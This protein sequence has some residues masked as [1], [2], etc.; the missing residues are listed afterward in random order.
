MAE[1]I[2]DLSEFLL[3]LYR[4]AREQAPDGFR[5]AT[6]ER[7]RAVVP[8]DFIAWGGGEAVERQVNEVLVLDQDERV[9]TEW[10]EVGPWDRFCDLTLERLNE[11]WKF[12]DVPGY[13]NTLAYNDHWR[14]YDVSH[15]MATITHQPLAGYV[16]FLGMFHEDMARPFAEDERARRYC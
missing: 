12:D 2:A 16:S 3:A 7:L 9:L 4:D 1:R 10:P 6:L 11:T 13:R 15:M 5:R 14:R 8:F